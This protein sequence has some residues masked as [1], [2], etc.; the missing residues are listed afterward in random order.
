MVLSESGPSEPVT[1]Q[2]GISVLMIFSEGGFEEDF[3]EFAEAE[4][5]LLA[6]PDEIHGNSP[7]PRP[8]GAS[9]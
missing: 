9:P 1:A 5:I 4:G 6:G 7:M 3:E 8:D 2:I